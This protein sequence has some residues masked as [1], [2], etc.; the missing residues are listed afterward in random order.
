[1]P[2]PGRIGFWFIPPPP[3]PLDDFPN[4]GFEDGLIFWQVINSRINLN[5]GSTIL[6]RPTP[7]DPTPNP[8]NF[9][10]FPSS[11]NATSVSNEIYSVTLV[12]DTPPGV[13]GTQ[14]LRLENSAVVNSG[15]ILYGPVV[16]SQRRI[17]VE[18]GD[19]VEFNWKALSGADA[20]VGDAYNPFAYIIEPSSGR[21]IILLDENATNTG[22][23]TDWQTASRVIQAGE[24]GTYQFVFICGSF[25]ATFG[26]VIGSAFLVDTVRLIKAV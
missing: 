9:Q 17:I 11:G 6:G 12:N 14:A 19:T 10:N 22:F 16:I 24:A 25:D 3:P 18:E 15:A 7:T 20:T 2:A 5:G 13:G 4:P 21:T 26:T 1:M 23:N 8:R